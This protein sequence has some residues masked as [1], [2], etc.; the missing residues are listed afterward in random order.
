MDRLEQLFI[1]VAAITL[2]VTL[3]L[4]IRWSRLDVERL[5]KTSWTKLNS[6]A[7]IFLKPSG[8]RLRICTPHD[9]FKP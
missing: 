5:T 4:L 1:I 6:K 7:S 3:A 2:G 9:A 8:Q